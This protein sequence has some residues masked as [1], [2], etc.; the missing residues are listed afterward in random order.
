MNTGNALGFLGFGAIMGLLPAVAPSWFPATGIDGSSARALWLQMMG[1]VQA[2]MGL[3]FLVRLQLIPAAIRWLASELR[4]AAV[5]T[6]APVPANAA[7]VTPFPLSA[8]LARSEQRTLLA[9]E[10]LE[11]NG[12]VTLRGKHAALWRALKVALLNEERL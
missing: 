8:A 6:N 4:P 3:F 7:S 10:R 9:G 11:T 12:A 2:T 1:V 5:L